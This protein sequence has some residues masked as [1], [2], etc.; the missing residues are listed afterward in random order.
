MARRTNVVLATTGRR[1]SV[2]MGSGGDL[3]SP[4]D[5]AGAP[6]DIPMPR[7]LPATTDSSHGAMLTRQQR[8][9]DDGHEIGQIASCGPSIDAERLADSIDSTSQE[10]GAMGMSAS[11]CTQ[12]AL[13]ACVTMF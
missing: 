1:M 6:A 7:R 4:P 5:S 8:L 11:S 2:A 12:I 9:R 13:A 10:R 3:E